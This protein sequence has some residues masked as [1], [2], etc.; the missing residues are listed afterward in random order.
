MFVRFVPVRSVKVSELMPRDVV[1]A[2]VEDAFVAKIEEKM[3]CSVNVLAVYVFGIV[4]EPWMYEL[5][6]A[7]KSLMVDAAWV[8]VWFARER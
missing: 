4:V 6:E 1:V 5:T 2:F 8:P 7:S 3:L